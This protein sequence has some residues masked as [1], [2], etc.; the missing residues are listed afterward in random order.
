MYRL[1]LEKGGG[2]VGLMGILCILGGCAEKDT[3]RCGEETE[4][5]KKV[6]V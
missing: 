1:A 5:G 6:D 3:G 4:R 2:Y